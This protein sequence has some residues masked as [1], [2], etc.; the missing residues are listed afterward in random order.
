[1]GDVI[2]F[3]SRKVLQREKIDSNII[4]IG[5][6]AD[7]MM[8]ELINEYMYIVYFTA[9]KGALSMDRN[10]SNLD[11]SC[12]LWTDKSTEKKLGIAHVVAHNEKHAAARLIGMLNVDSIDKVELK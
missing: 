3:K 12:E 11:I 6:S 1:M 4:P 7:L 10:D 8:S 5:P 2:D 9:P